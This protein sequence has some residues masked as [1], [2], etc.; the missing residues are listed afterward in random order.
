MIEIIYMGS[1]LSKTPDPPPKPL[2]VVHKP[3]KW[4]SPSIPKISPAPPIPE[5]D[6]YKN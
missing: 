6:P 3:E 2:Y 4:E 5:Y 1:L